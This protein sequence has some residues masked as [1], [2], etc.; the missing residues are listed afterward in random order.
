MR[1]GHAP[2]RISAGAYVLHSGLGKWS[3]DDQQAAGIHGMAAGAYPFLGKIPPRRFLRAVAAAEIATGAALLIPFVPALVGGT[4]LTGFA[5]GLLGMYWRT[6][7]MHKPGSI[8]PTQEG[9]A[10]SK[11][12]WLLGIALG[13]VIDGLADC[14]NRR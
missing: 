7:G 8:W 10:V 4:A 14:R 6:P 3:G 13:L 9:M 12:V 11:D 1:A 5:G 2:G